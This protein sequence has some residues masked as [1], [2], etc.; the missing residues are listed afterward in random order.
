MPMS[1]LKDFI[2]KTGA[3][4]LG[5]EL[6]KQIN[7]SHDSS[8]DPLFDHQS[9]IFAGKQVHTIFDIGARYGQISIAY[10]KWFSNAK[11]FAFEPLEDSFTRLKKNT[12]HDPNIIVSNYAV[13]DH[14]G[15][16]LLFI[17][18]FNPT[19]SI[20]D[21]VKTNTF[22]D[23]LITTVDTASVKCTTIDD[24][25]E[26][27]GIS[28]I[29][30]LKMDI[31]GAE[32]KAIEGASGLLKK[33]SIKMI[34]TEVLFMDMYKNQPFFHDISAALAGYGFQLYNI[35]NPWYVKNRLAWADAL[36][37]NREFFNF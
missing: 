28:E 11:V 8:R 3:A 5:S 33:E 24:F 9:A 17:T 12:S 18:K 27:E 1:F 21:P 7:F 31:Q 6:Y 15:E 34:Y 23:A 10:R 25:A 26:K 22:L 16:E 29:D 36:F 19:S 4:V 14:N 37:L 2:N 32:L 30:I 20:L 35:Y 13:S